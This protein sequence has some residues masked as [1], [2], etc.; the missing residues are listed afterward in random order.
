MQSPRIDKQWA[1]A[2]VIL[3]GAVLRTIQYGAMAS[4]SSDEAALAL[5][6]IDHGWIELLSEP[7][8]YYQVAPLGFLLLEKLAVEILGNTEAAFRLFPYLL[9]LA[10]LPLF[11]RVAARYLGPTAMLGAMIVFALSPSLILYAGMAKQ[12]SGDI[13]VTLL[14]VWTVLRCFEGPLDTARGARLGIG[15][16]LALLLSHA[17]VLVA[18]GLGVLLLSEAWRSR[19]RVAPR[20]VVCAGWA[21]GAAVLTYT[22]LATYSAETSE[23]MDSFWR[24]DFVPRPWLGLSELLWIPLRLAEAITYLV[25]YV[26]TPSSLPEYALG[27]VYGV[28]LL[29]GTA[30]LFRRNWR[31]ATAL[32]V[33][34]VMTVGASALRLLPL[35]GRVSLFIGPFLLIGCFAGFDGLRP[36][37]P[38]GFRSLVGPAALALAILPALAFLWIIRLPMIQ[39]E[40]LRIFREIGARWQ[41]GDELVVSRGMWAR[42]QAEYYGRRVGVEG[43]TH[44]DRVRGRHTAE[45]ILREYLKEIDAY[46]GSP[47]A[48]FYLDGLV[49]CEQE[50][51]RGYLGAIGTELYSI[52]PPSFMNRDVV[53]AHLYDLS[54]SDRLRTA[55]AATWPVPEC[56]D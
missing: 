35:S 17:A 25:A 26:N 47:R 3:I 42:V 29:A 37:V 50:A 51:M 12:Y 6:V 28:L 5:N 52:E 20:V 13:T 33:P 10:S 36:W 23:Y 40:T 45:E 11:W 4:L 30:H 54:D 21:I 32:A 48:W 19:D 24:T 56:D 8:A 49:G 7:L 27:A 2:L 44:I 39:V 15:G 38:A 1:T 46:R 18:A 34:V 55:N 41:P 31:T 53:S 43:W 14:L 9:S 16:G 22:S